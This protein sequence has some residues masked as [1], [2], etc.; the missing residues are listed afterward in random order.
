[1]KAESGHV[2][3]I[4][5]R[6][7]SV[8]LSGPSV[9]C[10]NRRPSR[11]EKSSEPAVSA[12]ARVARLLGFVLLFFPQRPRPYRCGAAAS[13]EKSRARCFVHFPSF[14][15]RNPIRHAAAVASQGTRYRGS[16]DALR[17]HGPHVSM[18][19]RLTA[20]AVNRKRQ[21]RSLHMI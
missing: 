14:I 16:R 11:L 21:L 20:T 12:A 5:R 1:M 4:R 15:P 17:T 8:G 3:G 10:T 19:R 6:A 18:G 2:Y 9:C 7:S 13:I